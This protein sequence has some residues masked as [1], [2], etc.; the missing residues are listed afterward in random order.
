M[1]GTMKKGL[2]IVLALLS[3]AALLRAQHSCCGLMPQ[4][5]ISMASFASDP[6]FVRAHLDPLP[7]TASLGGV[8]VNFPTSD[9]K[10]GSGYFMKSSEHPDKVI[11]MVHEW[12]GL[13]D[14]IKSE[15]DR[16]SKELGVSVL[17]IDLYDGK[18]ATTKEDASKYVQAVEVSRSRAIIMGALG[19]AGPSARIGTIGWCFGGGWSLQA[20]E[21]A[22]SQCD[23]CVMYYGQPESD[24]ARLD[25]L[26]APV[27]GLYG[28]KDKWLTPKVV[29][30]FKKTMAES[31]KT[32][33]V[34]SYDADHGFANPS[35]PIY[36]KKATAEAW[37]HTIEFFKKN[38]VK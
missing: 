35:N 26:K 15:A 16:L 30:D 33:T 34:Y 2:L 38:L 1:L 5:D 9:G 36:D 3:S 21:L 18:V 37:K 29:E 31:N 14:Y 20:A 23:A 27:L 22:G 32:I 28:K 6:E 19:Y 11:I 10:T 13:N 4:K 8:M 17:A 25:M 24:K 7:F 12:W